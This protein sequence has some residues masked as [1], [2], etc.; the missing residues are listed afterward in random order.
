MAPCPPLDASFLSDFLDA[1]PR[2]SR[3]LT[4]LSESVDHEAF[5]VGGCVRDAL[6]NRATADFDLTVAGDGLLYARQLANDL[7]A[8]YA[9]LDETQ[10]TGRVVTRR[11]STLDVT[12]MRGA[13]IAGDLG[14]RDFTIN[15]MAVRLIDAL[16][17]RPLLIDP[18]GGAD[19]LR[20]R[21]LRAVS[22][23]AFRDDPLR[24]LRAYRFAATLNLHIHPDT[25][26]WIYRWAHRLPE[27][28]A[29]RIHDELAIL[30]SHGGAAPCLANMADAGV[31]AAVIPESGAG[32][33][34]FSLVAAI[35]RLLEDSGACPDHLIAAALSPMKTITVS[36]RR[37]WAWLLRL[38][39]A[40]FDV[41]GDAA[42][43]PHWIHDL[44]TRRLRLSNRERKGLIRLL[45]WPPRIAASQTPADTPDAVLYDIVCET[46]IDTP[47]A[48]ALTWEIAR[49]NGS[50]S[51]ETMRRVRRLLWIHER[52]QRLRTAPP[53]L[54]GHDL[55]TEYRLASG[56]I[57][58]RL[59][60]RLEERQT[61][62]HIDT[63]EEAFSAVQEWLKQEGGAG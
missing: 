50:P 62:G 38:A 51:P 1:H 31:L 19:D 26:R 14:S 33:V 4:T 21:T 24:L 63:R 13:T 32:P 35:D 5:F 60:S 3:A 47:G 27:V 18:L 34:S 20:D 44:S 17:R 61:L 2:A 45:G 28:S 16:Q 46:D 55:M 48:A 9:P 36:A 23:Q 57:L 53:L 29:E 58:G 30:L 59:L 49:R 8:S 40:V 42:P 54:T 39:A 7:R 11:G 12:T 56:P 41:T 10:R 15:A 37:P 52:R 25:L 22:E 6:L 43:S